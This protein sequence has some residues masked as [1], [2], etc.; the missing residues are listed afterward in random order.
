MIN[1]LIHGQSFSGKILDEATNKPLA[2]VSVYFDN[3]TIGTVTNDK[4]EFSIEF[5]DAVK[6]ALVVSYLGY[7]KVFINDYRSKSN[8]TIFLKESINQLDTVVIEADDGMTRAAKMRLFKNEFLGKS[9]NGKSCK[10][11]NEKDIKL[12]YNKQH[13]TLTAWSN[14]PIVVKNKNLLYEISFEIVDFEIEMDKWGPLS[15]TY[16]GTSFYKDLNT[17]QKKQIETNRVNTYEGSIQHFVR[18]L[19]YMRLKEEG[20]VFGV[21]RFVVDPYEYLIISDE[22]DKGLKTVAL[23]EK[24]DIYY[25][26]DIVSIMHTTVDEFKIDKYG[27]YSPIPQVIFGGNMGRQRI[28]DALPIDYNLEEGK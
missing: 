15:V 19:Y 28:G 8:T 14:K 3:S 18:A 9:K 16:T 25:K 22:D 13:G 5:T 20:Y 23:K 27:N 11:L 4:G 7:E 1:T 10:I 12:R 17:K 2:Y 21:K 6:S 26:T 24:L